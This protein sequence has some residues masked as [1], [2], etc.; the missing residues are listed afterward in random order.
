MHRVP[1]SS[2][3]R[4]RARPFAAKGE[5]TAAALARSTVWRFRLFLALYTLL[6]STVFGLSAI[7]YPAS[8]PDDAGS[9]DVFH[10]AVAFV[11]LSAPIS[12]FVTATLLPISV[13]YADRRSWLVPIGFSYEREDAALARLFLPRRGF[14]R[15]AIFV[16]VTTLF[17]VPIALIVL[18]ALQPLSRNGFIA[19][20][21]LYSFA[22][23]AIILPLA[24]LVMCFD[25]NVAYIRR[26]GSTLA[27][28]ARA[29][30]TI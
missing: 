18:I 20:A 1:L 13:A 8:L 14:Q 26:C 21:V 4:L 27:G 5:G 22:T 24:L 2:S 28:T 11:L 29:C 15:H 17:L 12:S 16:A 10:Y 9:F 25:E 19:F 23:Q 7:W 6:S 3:E 30:L